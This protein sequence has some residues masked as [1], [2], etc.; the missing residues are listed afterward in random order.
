MRHQKNKLYLSGSQA[1]TQSQVK[2]LAESMILAEKI[3]T[4]SNR[5]KALIQ[6]L[7]PL[8]TKAKKNDLAN[9]R[10]IRSALF[11]L[12]A[13]QKLFKEIAPKYKDQSS[14]FRTTKIGHRVGDNA[15]KVK[16]EFK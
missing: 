14:Y 8:V 13:S 4:T 11:T 5:A 10:Q 9:F 3:V 12:K 16:I 2:S 1:K 15:L 6:Y 7:S